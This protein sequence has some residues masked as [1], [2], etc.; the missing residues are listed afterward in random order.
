[1]NITDFVLFSSGRTNFLTKEKI[2]CNNFIDPGFALPMTF[3]NSSAETAL[4]LF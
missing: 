2:I 1:M 3:Y 4:K